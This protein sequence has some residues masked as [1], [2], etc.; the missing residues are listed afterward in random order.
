MHP[1][2]EKALRD[3]AHRPPELVIPV[4]VGVTLLLPVGERMTRC[5]DRRQ[6]VALRLA[7]DCRAQALQVVARLVHRRADLG[8]DLDLALQELGRDLLLQLG[9]AGLHQPRRRLRQRQSL[10]IDEKILLLYPDAE[11]GRFHALRMARADTRAQEAARQ[12]AGA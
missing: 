12:R 5:G 2:D 7:R 10:K 8:S 9:R 6:P 3:A 11:R 4:P 1:T